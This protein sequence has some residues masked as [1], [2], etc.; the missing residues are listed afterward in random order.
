MNTTTQDVFSPT[1]PGRDASLTV[2]LDALTGLVSSAE[3]AVVFAS[4]VRLCVPSVCESANATVLG[5]DENVHAVSWPR[6]SFGQPHS[7]RGVVVTEFA[8]PATAEHPGY[9][10]VLSLR[11]ASRDRSHA[12]IAQ[13]LVERAMA[14]VERE[15][16]MELADRR[17]AVAENLEV[18]LTSNREISV[19]VGILMANHKIT[20]AEAFERLRRASQASNRKLRTIAVEVA[21]TGVIEL[22]EGIVSSD[23]GV[24]A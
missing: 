23:Q 22:P 15:R 4:L 18:A 21:R 10:G 2:V 16:L 11:F 8:A 6:E 5:A 19:A 14:T 12:F 17:Q 24:S 1:R 20:G 9:H 3:P 13:L 7:R